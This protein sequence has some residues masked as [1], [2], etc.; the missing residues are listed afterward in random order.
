M[1]AFRRTSPYVSQDTVVHLI[2]DILCMNGLEAVICAA[3]VLEV[4][5]LGSALRRRHG[6]PRARKYTSKRSWLHGDGEPS[7]RCNIDCER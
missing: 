4:Y 6:E 5:L 1:R 2:M 3:Q 7:N